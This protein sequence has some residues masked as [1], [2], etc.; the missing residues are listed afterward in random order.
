VEA[1]GEMYCCA[2]CASHAGHPE[3]KDRS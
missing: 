2:H 3:M 1:E